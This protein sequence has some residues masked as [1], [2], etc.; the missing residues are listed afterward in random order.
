MWFDKMKVMRT[1]VS[2]CREKCEVG[3]EE[4]GR[5]GEVC[6]RRK[7]EGGA[8]KRARIKAFFAFQTRTRCVR[9]PKYDVRT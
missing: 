1:V 4:E 6:G 8:T 2:R 5:V 7:S 9:E 3:G